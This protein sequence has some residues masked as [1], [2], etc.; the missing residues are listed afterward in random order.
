MKMQ[1]N[2]F[3][4]GL[5]AGEKQVGFWVSLASPYS[6]EVVAAAEFDWLVVDLEHTPGDMQTVL[7]Q[8]QA[9][10]PYHSTAIVRTP[11]N[12]PVIVKR[13]L[14]LGPEG[15]LFPMIQSADEAR[16]A[17][18]ATRYPPHGI[19]GVAGAA[20]GNRFGRVKDYYEQVESQTCVLIQ[21]ETCAALDQAEEIG[22]V[23]GVDG[24]FFGP[25][26]ISADMGMIGQPLHPDVWAR[27]MPAARKLMDMGVPVGTLVTDPAM[28]A[29]LLNDGFSFVACGTDVGT[30]AKATDSLLAQMRQSIDKEKT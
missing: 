15:I 17:I 13:L 5:K 4:A 25:A 7:G 8:L 28:A 10:A 19:R 11:V 27:I 29:D 23:E 24:V 20:R 6:A 21:I 18:E 12:D 14:D 2:R 26:D 3:L 30:L 22:G 9:I 1:T 16:A